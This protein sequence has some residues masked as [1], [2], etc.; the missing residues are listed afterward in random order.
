MQHRTPYAVEERNVLLCTVI[1]VG[2]YTDLLHRGSGQ[3]ATSPNAG[4]AGL[5]GGGT[6]YKQGCL[7]YQ[8]REHIKR[9]YKF[10]ASLYPFA[11]EFWKLRRPPVMWRF[12]DLGVLELFVL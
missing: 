7:T 10:N 3:V 1:H 11:G 2:Y 4:K 8:G 5:V 6:F 12:S 9:H